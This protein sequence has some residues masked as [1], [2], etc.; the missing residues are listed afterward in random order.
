MRFSST[1]GRRLTRDRKLPDLG[2]NI[3]VEVFDF[4][5]PE[6]EKSMESKFKFNAANETF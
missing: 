4:V 2:V 3:I 5:Q 6:K 1:Q